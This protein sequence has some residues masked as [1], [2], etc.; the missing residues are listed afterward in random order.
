MR[1]D[2]EKMMVLRPT[3]GY[4]KWS[5]LVSTWLTLVVCSQLS[6]AEYVW[7]PLRLGAGGFVTGIDI[8]DDGTRVVRTD[9]YGAYIW[10]P[11]I[12]EWVQL[13]T[14]DSFP[15]I[16]AGVEKS[17][18]GVYEVAI[19]PK[20]S[21]VLWL[22]HGDF[23][24]RSA[25]KGKSFR[26]PAGWPSDWSSKN[27]LANG[28]DSPRLLGQKMMVDPNNPDVLII[29]GRFDG[30]WITTDGGSTFSKLSDLPNGRVAAGMC[31][32]RSSETRGGRTQIAYLG[33]EG[34]GIYR[35]VNGGDSWLLMPGSPKNGAKHGRCSNGT[36]YFSDDNGKGE[37]WKTDGVSFT[38]IQPDP[39]D[40]RTRALAVDPFNPSRIVGGR[41][42]GALSVSID[43]GETWTNFFALNSVA[44][45]ADDV[46]WLE[47]TKEVFMSMGDIRF[48][49]VVKDRLWF[50]QGIGVWYTDLGPGVP[51]DEP[52]WKSSSKGIEEL[53]TYT[54]SAAPGSD[55]V[56]L[57]VLD[58]GVFSRSLSE[59]DLFPGS[60]G[61]T[62][63][64]ALQ[65]GYFSGFAARDP[66]FIVALNTK[67]GNNYSAYS[68]DDGETWTSFP[69]PPDFKPGGTMA[70]STRSNWLW[71]YGNG[72]KGFYT[73]DSGRSWTEIS[74]PNGKKNSRW[75]ASEFHKRNIAC[76][77]SEVDGRFYA[78]KMDDGFYR[79]VDGGVSWEQT[80]VGNFSP[81]GVDRFNALLR[82]TPG[83]YNHL[84]YTGGEVR[85]G[86]ANSGNPFWRSVDGGN[87]WIKVPNVE[88][89]QSFAFGS[90]QA[91]GY[92]ALVIS[93]WVN[94]EYGIWRSNDEGARWEKI[95]GYPLGSFDRINTLGMMKDGT[96][97]V[98][99]GY[100]G[101]GFV[102][103]APLSGG[104]AR[105]SGPS[106][107]LPPTS[108]RIN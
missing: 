47:W 21:S 1:I 11:Q 43:G 54:A 63:G 74:L 44:R 84:W 86:A 35:S 25:D 106:K 99:I 26:V 28:G 67:F 46:P 103:G 30:V 97:R 59:F 93:G 105:V 18:Q 55:H 60:H 42:D 50:A 6:F 83:V 37:L 3:S 27:F 68:V 51:D 7:K 23:L 48:D 36:Y 75:H 100:S 102:Y 12:D 66:Q 10:D 88:E 85:N 45:V 13:A 41:N 29:G 22:Q 32:D 89:V 38:N 65:N 14:V 91:S 34:V 82:C 72:G 17:V 70:V 61:T 94:N 71:F 52:V 64:A 87:S 92:P 78:F 24:L 16:T 79:S 62:G 104:A 4:W 90:V 57:G 69:N 5:L 58:R 20:D 107:P 76:A 95:G 77:D 49:P 56:H 33:I 96:D 80:K 2:S 73:L 108:V 81:A 15:S 8:A 19:Y 53:V 31:F 101:S 98:I 39:S 40:L 9:V